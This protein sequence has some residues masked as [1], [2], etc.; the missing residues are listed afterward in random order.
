MHKG[1]EMR[2]HQPFTGRI[3]QFSLAGLP[4]LQRRN[5]SGEVDEVRF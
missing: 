2:T 3:G 4:G 1:R 5:K